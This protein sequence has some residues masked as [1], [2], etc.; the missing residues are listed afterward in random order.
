MSSDET[1]N[2]TELEEELREMQAAIAA[3][4][5]ASAAGNVE[6]SPERTYPSSYISKESDT[7]KQVASL[8]QR[9]HA[10]IAREGAASQL[11]LSSEPAPAEKLFAIQEEM[12]Q[13]ASDFSLPS[14]VLASF[15]CHDGQDWSSTTGVLGRW[16]LLD[17]QTMFTEWRDQKEIAEAGLYSG[18]KYQDARKSQPRHPRINTDYWYN[19]RWIPIACSRGSNLGGDLICIDMNPIRAA[20]EGQVILYFTE[21]P[22]RIV[23]ADS[24]SEWLSACVGDCERGVYRF[25]TERRTYVAGKVPEAEAEEEKVQE[26]KEPAASSTTASSSSA[27]SSSAMPTSASKT[28][29]VEAFM[30]SALES[31]DFFIRNQT[32][33]LI[34]LP[35]ND[36]GLLSTNG[37]GADPLAGM[38]VLRR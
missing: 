15:A 22:E 31:R 28:I 2:L 18:K 13:G 4:H 6:A 1:P 25:D 7:Y 17:C 29:G 35:E 26:E 5:A 14:D 10:W 23:L 21:S 20:H 12:A 27:A 33:D 34:Y 38:D 30:Y 3:H 37:L 32:E 24:F 16:Y 11:V 9:F 8:W 19:P 36:F